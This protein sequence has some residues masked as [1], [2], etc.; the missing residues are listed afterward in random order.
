M[1]GLTMMMKNNPNTPHNVGGAGYPDLLGVKLR[2][3]QKISEIG[4][5]GA[6]NVRGLCNNSI[7]NKRKADYV[8]G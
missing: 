6:K 8:S 3:A 2:H 7:T 1:L 5:V 4:R